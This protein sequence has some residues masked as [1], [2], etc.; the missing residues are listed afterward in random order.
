MRRTAL[1]LSAAAVLG[2]AAPALAQT[3]PVG[4]SVDTKDGV[5]VTTTVNGQPG[6]GV[7]SRDGQV[8][9]GLS[10]QVP[11]CTDVSVGR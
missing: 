5:A 11:F 2:V 10:Y 1:V 7:A 3:L 9:V 8:C 4:A 6:V